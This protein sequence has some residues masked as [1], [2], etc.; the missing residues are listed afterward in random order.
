MQLSTYLVLIPVIITSTLPS[1]TVFAAP[2]S[3]TGSHCLAAAGAQKHPQRQSMGKR[4]I[5]DQF[6]RWVPLPG[7]KSQD[8][9]PNMAMSKQVLPLYEIELSHFGIVYHEVMDRI[10]KGK[11]EPDPKL[12]EEEQKLQAAMYVWIK[13]FEPNMIPAV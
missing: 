7:F 12:N 6:T 8:P 2:Y 11:M 4:T 13:N 5:F 10:S 3:S 1:I 9:A